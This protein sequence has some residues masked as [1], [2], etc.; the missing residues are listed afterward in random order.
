[1]LGE[2]GVTAAAGSRA[3]AVN[4]AAS[5][6]N[7]MK[8][9]GLSIGVEPLNQTEGGVGAFLPAWL[10]AAAA[11]GPTMADAKRNRMSRA[12]SKQT[13][14]RIEDADLLLGRGRFADDLPV[15]RGTLHAAI[16]R[17]P[18]AHAELVS[19]D[20]AAALAMPGVACV[21][22]GED[23]RHWTRPFAVAVK[24]AMQQW[25][26]AVD[27]V[28]HVGEPVAVVLAQ[29]RHLAEDA[30]ERIAVEYGPLAAIVDPEAAASPEAPLLHPA[31]GS[32][33][34]SDR[35]FRYGDPEAAFTAAVHRIAITTRIRAMP[36]PRSKP[37][38]CSPSIC[39]A[40]MPTKPP[41]ISR[42]RWRCTRSWRWRSVS[43][44]TACASRP[45]P[46]PAAA[47]GQ[48]MRYFRTSC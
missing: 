13:M 9:C 27:R 14:K 22:T 41:P 39:R 31:V 37:L 17:S 8:R 21:V 35:S 7:G 2:V 24:T 19:I 20:A 46:I 45:R 29:D 12:V 32:N 47:S 6:V 11:S 4:S 33:I 40:R 5:A 43:R 26:L 36:A 16:L 15:P 10:A 23:A 18:Y 28:R 3:D 25:C 1:L 42:G 30:A 48:S 38:S 34:V 44:L